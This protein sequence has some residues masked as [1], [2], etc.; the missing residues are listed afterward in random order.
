MEAI[1]VD[2]V[3][4]LEV[5]ASINESNVTNEILPALETAFSKALLEDLFP[6]D[7]SSIAA[8]AVEGIVGLSTLG[9]DVVQTDNSC[10]NVQ[11]TANICHVVEGSVTL[12]W[13]EDVLQDL[14]A[15]IQQMLATCMTNGD[16]LDVSDG[17]VRVGMQAQTVTTA[18]TPTPTMTP[19]TNTTT[20]EEEQNSFGS[21]ISAA[22]DAMFGPIIDY[23]KKSET[24]RRVVIYSPF[25]ILLLCMCCCCI[26]FKSDNDTYKKKVSDSDD[27]GDDGD[28]DFDDE[29]ESGQDSD[30]DD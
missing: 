1:V 15:P 12:Y 18:P 6:S 8:T 21:S 22:L 29:I 27:D 10:S 25:F 13:D 9:V 16:F 17:I 4:E 26:C 24:A 3:Y 28:D 14:T 23:A 2:Y 5:L 11:S 20:N 7:C 30:G 19:T